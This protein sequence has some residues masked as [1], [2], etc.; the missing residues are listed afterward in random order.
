MTDG[1]CIDSDSS[2]ESEPES[3]DDISIIDLIIES[4]NDVE[5]PIDLTVMMKRTEM[6]STPAW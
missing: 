1:L 3:Q 2:T 5:N 6:T 4:H